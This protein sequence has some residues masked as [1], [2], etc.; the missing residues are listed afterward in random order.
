MKNCNK[1]NIQKE[2]DQFNDHK[3]ICDKCMEAHN[4]SLT[5]KPVPEK[6]LTVAEKASDD[7]KEKAIADAGDAKR[8]KQKQKADIEAAKKRIGA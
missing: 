4:K 1:C 3:S 6:E 7:K 8:Q 5:E 2:E